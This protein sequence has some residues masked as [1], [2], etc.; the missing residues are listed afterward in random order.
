M[1]FCQNCGRRCDDERFCPSC[2]AALNIYS[3]ENI[4]PR[5]QVTIV[6][7]EKSAGL[8]GF[9][10]FL[11]PGVGTIYVGKVGKGIGLMVLN[12]FSWVIGMIVGTAI[13]GA[14]AAAG[15]AGS[16]ELFAAGGV[17]GL[18]AYVLVPV[19]IYIACIISAAKDAKRYNQYLAETGSTPW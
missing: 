1:V 4:A 15:S 9:L 12:I 13:I 10:S 6:H 18:L 5:Q 11:I 16:E 2:G 7:H 14:G 17:V 8:A 19:I 3:P